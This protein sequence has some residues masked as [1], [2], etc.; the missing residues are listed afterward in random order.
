MQEVHFADETR[1]KRRARQGEACNAE[2]EKGQGH[3]P[4]EADGLRH[5]LTPGLAQHGAGAE[6]ERDL[7]NSM[8]E[9]MAQACNQ[10][11]GCQKGH[12]EKNVAQVAD[13]GIG[14]TALEM[15]LAQSHAGTEQNGKSGKS[16]GSF[17]RPGA[18]K[19]GRPEG[20]I[21]AADGSEDTAFHY[22]H[23]VKQRGDGRGCD[24]GRGQPG[25]QGED[26]RFHSKPDEGKQIGDEEKT[27]S[28][29]SGSRPAINKLCAAGAAVEHEDPGKGKRG[30][31]DGIKDIF[32]C[33]RHGTP[34]ALMG[35]ERDR[36]KCQQFIEKVHRDEVCA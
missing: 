17:L 12:T 6:K 8:E 27:V 21:G 28:R 20:I 26:G 15:L 23:R 11:A 36:D 19:E 35:N 4:P 7:H 13:G 31:A 16:H 24:A 33:S 34:V 2:S 9:H 3:F 30:A 29:K 10:A 22:C 5:V 32:A 14:E 1:E 25:M 18:C